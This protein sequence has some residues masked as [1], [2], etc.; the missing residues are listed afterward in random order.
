MLYGV[1][2]PAVISSSK[3]NLLLIQNKRDD[4][5]KGIKCV[6]LP[7]CHFNHYNWQYLFKYQE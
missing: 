5:L 1:N 4:I 7:L 2:D 6:F 3:F